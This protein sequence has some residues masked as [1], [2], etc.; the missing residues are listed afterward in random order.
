LLL[1][2]EGPFTAIVAIV[3]F[4]EH[5]SRHAFGGAA[6]IFAGAIVLSWSVP[7]TTRDF[8]GALLIAGACALWAVDNNLTQGLTL[9]DPVA[10]VTVKAAAASVVNITLAVVIGASRPMAT[11]IAAA[12]AVGAVAYGL[13]IVF[14]AYALRLLGAAREAAIFATAPFVGAAVAVPLLDETLGWRATGAAVVMAI[15]VAFMLSE[16]HS[17]LHMHEPLV[18]EHAHVHDEHHQ[19]EHASDVD[20]SEPHS[21]LHRHDHLVHA[22]RHVSDL[23]HRHPHDGD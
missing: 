13:S 8:T 3:W 21:H 2:L 1:N 6:L 9:R 16:R 20:A 19:H 4:R 7:G 15:G 11:T 23:H 10:V 5:L 22:H 14:D 17:H 18:H 12:L